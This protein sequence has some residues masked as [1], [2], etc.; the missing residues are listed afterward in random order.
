MNDYI[1]AIYAQDWKRGGSNALDEP[2]TDPVIQSIRIE[3][4]IS[5]YIFQFFER[6]FE[7]ISVPNSAMMK[8]SIPT[9][10]SQ[11]PYHSLLDFLDEQFNQEFGPDDVF[12]PFFDNTKA[13]DY[14]K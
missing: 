12:M 8:R 13:F 14:A 4:F 1:N 10:A 3:K 7:D 6:I 11:I 9:G 2:W 5:G